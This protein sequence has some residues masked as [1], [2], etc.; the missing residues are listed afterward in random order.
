MNT[1]NAENQSPLLHWT[2]SSLHARDQKS[3]FF[4]ESSQI[5]KKKPMTLSLGVAQLYS[6]D[7]LGENEA[8]RWQVPQQVWTFNLHSHPPPKYKQRRTISY[9]RKVSAI[10]AKYVM[11]SIYNK[12]KKYW[13]R[14]KTTINR[15]HDNHKTRIGCHQKETSRERKKWTL[16]Y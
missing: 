12:I 5:K 7:K 16:G 3:L 8:Q 1:L 15:R 14:R 10:E 9:W 6:S 11:R 13:G 2:T 4:E